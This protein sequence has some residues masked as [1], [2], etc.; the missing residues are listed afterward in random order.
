M[1]NMI[2][3]YKNRF[4]QPLNQTQIS[5]TILCVYLTWL[6]S[7]CHN[8]F[9]KIHSNIHWYGQNITS[10]DLIRSKWTVRLIL[11]CVS[12]REFWI[13]FY[14]LLITFSC[15]CLCF[16]ETSGMWIHGPIFWNQHL[17]QMF[18][19]RYWSMKTKQNMCFSIH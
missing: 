19:I 12:A 14:L 2:L 3:H 7:K 11:N 4:L 6:S 9:C 18:W 15:V 13:I 5:S 16:H 17:L 1:A 8:V 10:T